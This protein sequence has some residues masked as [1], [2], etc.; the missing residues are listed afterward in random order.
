MLKKSFVFAMFVGL[1]FTMFAVQAKTIEVEGLNTLKFSKTSI[2]VNAGEKVTIKLVNKTKMPAVAMS[3]DWVLL[4][5]GV[6]A[7][8]VDA[9]ASAAGSSASYIPAGMS[10]EILAHTG[11]VAGGESKTVTFTAPK[12]P[13]NYEYICT[14]PG[15]FAAGMKGTLVVKAK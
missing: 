6:D 15:H 14:F 5:A 1:S 9:A 13:G 4:A 8:K 7:K 3:H 10:K 2:T 11:M 12:K